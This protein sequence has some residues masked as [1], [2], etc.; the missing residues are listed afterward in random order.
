MHTR[1][2]QGDAIVSRHKLSVSQNIRGAIGGV[3]K[4]S[5]AAGQALVLGVGS[6]IIYQ[7]VQFKLRSRRESAGGQID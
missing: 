6:F 1:H 5:G 2:R 7:L 3:G 4:G